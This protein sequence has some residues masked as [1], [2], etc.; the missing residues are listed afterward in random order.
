MSLFMKYTTYTRFN[1]EECVSL[2]EKSERPQFA[3]DW[4]HVWFG[5]IFWLSYSSH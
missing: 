4:N 3:L 5:Y 1:Q 2:D